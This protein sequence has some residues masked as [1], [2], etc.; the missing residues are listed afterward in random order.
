M[1]FQ[2]SWMFSV[3]LCVV[4]MVLGY[5]KCFLVVLGL[6]LMVLGCCQ[7]FC[8]LCVHSL[9][10]LISESSLSYLSEIYV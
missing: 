8:G 5:F 10:K 2:G 1:G 7:G 4:F 6:I 9:I 3:V